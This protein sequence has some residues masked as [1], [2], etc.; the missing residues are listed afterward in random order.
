MKKTI[1]YEKHLELNAKMVEFGGFL[2]PVSYEGI[3]QEHEAVRN[4]VGVFDVSHMGEI[5]VEGQDALKFVNYI[6]SNLI[7]DEINKVTYTLLINEDGYVIDD[8]LVYVI[9]PQKILLVV[10]ASNIE[11]DFAWLLQNKGTFNL[12]I[13]NLSDEYGLIALQGPESK[14]NVNQ[15]L[16]HVVTDLNFMQFKIIPYKD[17]FVIVSRTG[18]TGE[19][20][21]E[22]YGRT[23]LIVDLFNES[24]NFAKPCGL[25]CRDTL[26]FE[27]CLPLYGH[28]ISDKIT[29][30]E[31]GLG[32]AVKL[33]KPSF[34]GK[35]KLLLHKQN[36]TRKLVGFKLLDK[37]IA[38]ESYPIMKNDK[39]IGY[40]TTGYLSPTLGSAL[41]LALVD[42]NYSNIGDQFYVSIRKNQVLAEVIQKPFY[43]KK[44]QTEEKN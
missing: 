32:F 12:N 3:T 15:L 10:N 26:R 7:S 23:H 4:N 30:F 6:G 21:F 25:G 1:L 16:E 22:I 8:L 24:L 42:K 41:G 29:P 19:D 43:T 18:Y 39:E 20:G 36:Q 2:M 40:V 38:R 35:E 44:Y 37:G 34:I 14:N 28:E 27:A 5:I 11:K 9:T 17:L 31:A 13:R 33:K